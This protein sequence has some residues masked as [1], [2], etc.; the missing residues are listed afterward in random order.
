MSLPRLVPLGVLAL[1]VPAVALAEGPAKKTLAECTAIALAEQPTLK[2][3]SA[4]VEAARER[5]WETPPRTSRR[6]GPRTARRG[7]TRA[8]G[9]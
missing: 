3:A 6:W 2:A 8:P 7:A 4:S 1:V 5:V 9:A